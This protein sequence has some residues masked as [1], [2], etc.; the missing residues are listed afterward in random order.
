MF[1]TNIISAFVTAHQSIEAS[2]HHGLPVWAPIQKRHDETKPL[3]FTFTTREEYLAWVDAW[4]ARYNEIAKASRHWKPRRKLSHP[5][6]GGWNAVK[7][8]LNLR[9]EANA[10]LVIRKL[11]K[12]IAWEMQQSRLTAN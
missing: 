11:A 12:E 7:N 6:S 2:R 9:A 10:M 3:I 8:V 1:D 4:K 5:D